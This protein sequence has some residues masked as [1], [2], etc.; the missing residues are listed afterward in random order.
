LFGASVPWDR[1]V[2]DIVGPPDLDQR[3]PTLEAGGSNL[4]R[5]GFANG[6]RC[7]LPRLLRQRCHWALISAAR[8]SW[9]PRWHLA[10]HD[11][12]SKRTT[13][14]SAAAKAQLGNYQRI[15]RAKQEATAA[16]AEA[17]GR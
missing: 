2:A 11:A 1:H 3:L 6:Q 12:T 9:R 10:T 13:E 8:K 4:G 15:A 5:A 7:R 16:R 14:A 17:C